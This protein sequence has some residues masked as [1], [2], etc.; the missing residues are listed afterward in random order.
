MKANYL[1]TLD[2]SAFK[3]NNDNYVGKVRLSS[4][5]NGLYHIYDQGVNPQKTPY[6]VE[7]DENRK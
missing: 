4:T 3:R 2:Q 1:I 7:D 6:T 5:H